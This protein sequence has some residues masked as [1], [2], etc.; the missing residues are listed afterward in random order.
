VIGLGCFRNAVV[1]YALATGNSN[2]VTIVLSAT[3]TVQSSNDVRV[4][5]PDGVTGIDH[6][7]RSRGQGGQV[8][9]EFRAGTLMQIAPPDFVI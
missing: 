5:L 1:G 7:R 9:P 8:P 4:C 3:V 2:A 6:V